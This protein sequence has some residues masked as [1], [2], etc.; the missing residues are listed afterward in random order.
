MNWESGEVRKIELSMPRK[1]RNKAAYKTKTIIFQIPAPY[2]RLVS[3]LSFEV[4][5][6]VGDTSH[7]AL[8]QQSIASQT[9]DVFARELLTN[10]SAIDARPADFRSWVL[11]PILQR[12]RSGFSDHY[13]PSI[14]AGV[15]MD[16]EKEATIRDATEVYLKEDPV[17]PKWI[18]TYRTVLPYLPEVRWHLGVLTAVGDVGDTEYYFKFRTNHDKIMEELQQEDPDEAREEDPEDTAILTDVEVEAIVDEGLEKFFEAELAASVCGCPVASS[19]PLI[20]ALYRAIWWR[21]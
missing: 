6:G 18:P 3:Q 12:Q 16:S 21:S 9:L 5:H 4:A 15:A 14:R 13:A 7:E 19:H 10:R 2:D 11:T 20:C 17:D 8:R 1:L